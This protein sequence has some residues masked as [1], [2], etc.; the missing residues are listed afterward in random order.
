MIFQKICSGWII[1]DWLKKLKSNSMEETKDG[2]TWIAQSL[3]QRRRKMYN[4]RSCLWGADAVDSWEITI[5]L[6]HAQSCFPLKIGALRVKRFL[7][8]SNWLYCN[9]WW[10]YGSARDNMA[11]YLTWLSIKKLTCDCIKSKLKDKAEKYWRILGRRVM[12]NVR[13]IALKMITYWCF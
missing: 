4:H 6:H 7:E 10:S 2:W 1:E 11:L 13:K 12:L 9:R 8:G 3:S 5:L